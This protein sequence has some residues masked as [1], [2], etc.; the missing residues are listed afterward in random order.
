M[1]LTET[2]L[3]K[4]RLNLAKTAIVFEGRSHSYG[5]LARSVGQHAGWLS[6][7]GVK[8]GDRVAI[9]LP[10]GLEFIHLHLAVLALGAVTLPLNPGYTAAETGYFLSDSGASLLFTDRAGTK[11][12]PEAGKIPTVLTDDPEHYT[13]PLGEAALE[14]PG[15]GYPTR[16]DDAA[17]ICYTSGTTGQ[18]KGAVIT[19]QNLLSNTAALHEV[20]HWTDR[21]VL[22][23]VLPLFHVHGLCVALHGSLCK[24][25]TVVM[26]EKFEA[27]RVWRTIAEGT[28][29][30]FM[31]VPTIYQRLVADL[32]GRRPDTGSMRVFVSG[33]A[34]LGE[35]LFQ[36][37]QDL[38]G[39]RIL[40][41]YGMTEAQMIASNPYDP[42][43][44]IPKSVGY[45]LPGVAIR[46]VADSG[47]EVAAGEIGEVWVKG[48]NVFQCYWHRPAETAKAGPW[49]KTG[50]LGYRDPRDGGRLYLVGRARELVISGGFNVYPKEVENVL[51]NHPAVRESAVFAL[52]D[53]DLGERVAAAVVLEKGKG[54]VTAAELVGHCKEHLV[55]Y[56]CPKEVFFVAELPKNAMGKV[57]KQVLKSTLG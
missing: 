28:C 34:P 57:Q 33:S 36:K 39:F 55:G 51:D 44:R 24:G 1:N 21:D 14:E 10:K 19:H 18:P 56:K 49:L 50:D 43:R 38:T 8:K 6:R 27:A 41:R 31:G 5:E 30:M 45:P 17:M 42:D 15:P 53:E 22:L 13:G 35:G 16:A 47:E 20:W 2:I 3:E 54:E 48:D 26:L 23:H 11:R 40:E 7:L 25:A 29:T 52:D 12:G 9:Q 4:A 32:D 37:F 46:V